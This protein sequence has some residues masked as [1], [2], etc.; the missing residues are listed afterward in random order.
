MRKEEAYKKILSSL[1]QRKSGA[2]TADICAATALPLVTVNELLPKAADEFSGHLKVTAS[3]EILYH[4]PNGFIN[5]YKNFKAVFKRTAE[6]IAGVVK[7]AL[8]LLFKIWIMV[9]L[10]GYFILF[11]AIA[12]ASVLIQVAAKSNDKGGSGG[13]LNFGLFDILI[14]FWFY[15]EITNSNRRYGNSILRKKP[16]K[17]K[18]PMHKAIFSFI[19]GEEDPNKDWIDV[20]K[21]A[22]IE[23]I[24][25]NNGIISL[26][27]Y[28]ALTGESS[29]EAEKSI[30]SFCSGFEGSPE[31]TE[32]GVIY[33]HFEK[34]LMRSSYYKNDRL[35]PPVKLLKTFSVNKKSQNGWFIAINAFNLLFGSYFL[36]NSSVFGHLINEVQYHAAPVIYAYTHYFLNFIMEEPQNLIRV[37]LGIVPVVFSVF[38]WLIPAI[39]C[40]IMK[41]ENKEI[42]LSNFKR[43]SFSKIWKSP[44]KIEKDD[45]LTQAEDFKPD[46]HGKAFEKVINDLSLVSV[47]EIEIADNGKEIYSF[48]ELEKEKKAIEKQR[49]NINRQKYQLGQTIFDSAQ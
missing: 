20:K 36:Y 10:V 4:F 45:F 37:I 24:Q 12:L 16:L 15:S 23:F 9:M 19:F 8:A 14:R 28:M 47:P 11:L 5:R 27:E 33:Y 22:V 17:I 7:K 18:R 39:R 31:V 49:E 44:E 3:G 43:F 40:L 48:K 30:L 6:K 13:S 35:N 26:A 38:F 25:S 1:K 21:K 42:K 34:I 41:K 29:P 2:T 46:D 32:D